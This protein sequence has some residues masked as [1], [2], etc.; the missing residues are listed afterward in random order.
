MHCRCGLLRLV[1][2]DTPCTLHAALRY[3]VLLQVLL[4]IRMI[5]DLLRSE[6]PNYKMAPK[7]E[8]TS[9]FYVLPEMIGPA[10]IGKA[11]THAK[12]IRERTGV[13]IEVVGECACCFML[14]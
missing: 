9:R 13:R 11:G 14:Q 3:T 2:P 5:D 7:P 4:C 8:V 1:A 10:I 6:D 12:H